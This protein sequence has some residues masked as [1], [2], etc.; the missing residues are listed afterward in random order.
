[1]LLLDLPPG[2]GDIA[3]SVAQM[4]PGAELLIVTTPQLAAAEVAERAGAIAQ[5]THQRVTGVIENMSYL[6]CPHCGE[7]TEVFGSGGGETVAAALTRLSGA[8]VPLLGQVPID[9][10]LREGGDAGVPLVL[11]DPDSPAG[12][13]LR[14]IADDLGAR[15]RGLAGR[16]LGI[17]PR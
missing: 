2:T 10:R 15:S 17:T 12:L 11:S 14:K 5:Q 16:S 9:I 1:V 6:I 4:L 7:P 3:I 13:A 8:P